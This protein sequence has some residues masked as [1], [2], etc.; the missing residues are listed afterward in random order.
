MRILAGGHKPNQ[1]LHCFYHLIIVVCE[2]SRPGIHWLLYFCGRLTVKVNWWYGCHGDLN[3][4]WVFPNR[5]AYHCQSICRHHPKCTLN[6]EF[7]RFFP[8]IIW[9]IYIRRAFKHGFLGECN[10]FLVVHN[11]AYIIQHVMMPCD[12]ILLYC[13]N[14]YFPH[15][16]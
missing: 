1:A 15:L 12:C 14:G 16:W 5:W 4:C 3:T 10:A 11:H 8:P 9:H 13:A 7:G 6:L 2:P